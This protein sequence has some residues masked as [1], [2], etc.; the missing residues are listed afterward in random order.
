M[1]E[2]LADGREITWVRTLFEHGAGMGSVVL[3]KKIW[4]KDA[5][6]NAIRETI[7]KARSEQVEEKVKL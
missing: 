4:S 5:E 6:K 3:D 2:T 7:Q 1:K